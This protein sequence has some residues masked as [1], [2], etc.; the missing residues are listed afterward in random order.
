[1]IIKEYRYVNVNRS[2]ISAMSARKQVKEKNRVT[3]KPDESLE[4]SKSKNPVTHNA[5]E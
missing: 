5:D 2:F 1:M 3:H 4:I